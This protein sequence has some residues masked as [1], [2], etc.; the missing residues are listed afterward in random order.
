MFLNGVAVDR[1]ETYLYRRRAVNTPFG[2]Y[3][4]ISVSGRPAFVMDIS[5]DL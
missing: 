5:L 4:V 1:D 2:V 3:G